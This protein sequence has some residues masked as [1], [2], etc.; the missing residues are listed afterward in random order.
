[1]HFFRTILAGVLLTVGP[2][3][4]AMGEDEDWQL[5]GRVLGLV[6]SVVHAAV[7]SNDRQ[8]AEKGI[9]R[10]L[11]GEH[12]EA[13]RLAADIAGDAFEDVPPQYKDSILALAK[14][15]AA[16]ARKEREQQSS[17]RSAGSE[18]ALQARRDLAAMGLWYFDS[19]QLLDA[20]RRDDALAVELFV[21]GRGVDL[22]ARNADGLTAL[23]LAQRRNNRRLVD[24]LASG[25]L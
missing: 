20:V 22:A 4:A 15:L 12:P 18:T 17:L 14:D 3:K 9:D 10:L 25:G 6:Q 5:F 19:A 24:L 11:S 23:E 8:A 7:Q 16:L 13:N 2:A 21:A 1:M